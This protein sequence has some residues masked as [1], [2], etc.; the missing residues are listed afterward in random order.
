M[1]HHY[2]D[3]FSNPPALILPVAL[4]APGG[5][6]V[7]MRCR[8]KLDTAADLSVLPRA[9]IGKLKLVAFNTLTIRQTGREEKSYLV[10][11]VVEGRRY[12][13]EAITHE[14]PYALIG[15]DILNEVTLIA[16]GP[17]ERFEIVHSR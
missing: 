16:D 9:C 6:G 10:E 11:I 17:K 8:G 14:R 15:R 5:G 3:E 13:V 1:Q 4:L 7:T 12:W 2:S